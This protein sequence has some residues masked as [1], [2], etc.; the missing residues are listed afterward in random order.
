MEGFMIR[1]WGSIT[2]G[3]RSHHEAQ[4]IGDQP[5][6]V[7]VSTPCGAMSTWGIAVLVPGWSK[8]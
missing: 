2:P 6:G 8:L 3:C 4:P 1:G 5:M 7:E